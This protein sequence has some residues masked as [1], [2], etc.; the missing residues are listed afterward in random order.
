MSKDLKNTGRG[1]Y[2]EFHSRASPAKFYLPEAVQGSNS[3]PWAT[4]GPW[5]WPRAHPAG[6]S[7]RPSCTCARL[8]GAAAK[9]VGRGR[10]GPQVRR[11][12]PL[13]AGPLP[14]RWPDV[15]RW[16]AVDPVTAAPPE[17]GAAVRLAPASLQGIWRRAR[18]APRRALRPPGSDGAGQP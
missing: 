16:A 10:C 5:G 1:A 7:P 14:G 6:L 8:A 11:P 17:A 9:A 18:P 3:A 4:R 2:H 13:G 12:R 15:G